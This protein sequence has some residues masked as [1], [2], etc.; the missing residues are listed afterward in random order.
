MLSCMHRTLSSALWKQSTVAEGCSTQSVTSAPLHK[1]VSSL[2]V[3]HN[4]STFS[5]VRQLE[6]AF[7]HGNQ[8]PAILKGGRYVA[9][10]STSSSTS[11][12]PQAAGVGA[13]SDPQRPIVKLQVAGSETPEVRDGM[14]PLIVLHS[15]RCCMPRHGVPVVNA[16]CCMPVCMH[17]RLRAACVRYLV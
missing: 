4:K 14:H 1:N 2:A 17:C 7:C 3:R 8:L 12:S 13:T 10:A 6:P 16:T 15:M 11:S 5:S 9:A